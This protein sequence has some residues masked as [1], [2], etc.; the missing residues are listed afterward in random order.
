MRFLWA[1]LGCLTAVFAQNPNPDPM[2]LLATF[3]G[4]QALLPN[5]TGYN[6]TVIRVCVPHTALTGEQKAFVG[7]W[8]NQFHPEKSAEF[9]YTGVLEATQVLFSV[10]PE[11]MCHLGLTYSLSL[12]ALV[13]QGL[14][15]PLDPYATQFQ[16]AKG[17]NPFTDITLPSQYDLHIV[18]PGQ[19]GPQ[20]FGI[21]FIVQNLAL[22]VN[23]TTLE[24]LNLTAPPPIN[25]ASVWPL[26]YGNSWT[27]AEFFHYVEVLYAAGIE[28]PY[29]TEVCEFDQMLVAFGLSLNVPLIKADGTC[30]WQDPVFEAGVATSIVPLLKNKLVMF[31]RWVYMNS[32]LVQEF[33]NTPVGEWPPSRPLPIPLGTCTLSNEVQGFAT[34]Y[35]GIN[36]D[37]GRAAS[38]G[39]VNTMQTWSWGIYSNSSDPDL[40][41]DFLSFLIDCTNPTLVTLMETY[42]IMP[43]FGHC[44]TAAPALDAMIANSPSL[45]NA[46][47]ERIKSFPMTYPGPPPAHT[48]LLETLSFHIVFVGTIMKQLMPGYNWT[49]FRVPSYSEIP[50]RWGKGAVYYP[51]PPN[52]DPLTIAKTA[53]KEACALVNYISLPTCRAKNLQYAITTCDGTNAQATPLWNSAEA[54]V[55]CLATDFANWTLAATPSIP[56]TCPYDTIDTP[57]G[58]ASIIIPGLVV[59]MTLGITGVLIKYWDAF[60]FRV[61]SRWISLLYLLGIV[62]M[63]LAPPLFLVSGIGSIFVLSNGHLLSIGGVWAKLRRLY[64][65]LEAGDKLKSVKIPDSTLCL[66]ILVILLGNN[67]IFAINILT[68]GP[69]Y[70]LIPVTQPGDGR[71]IQSVLQYNMGNGWVYALWIV[72]LGVLLGHSAKMAW[73]LSRYTSSDEFKKST[74]ESEAMLAIMRAAQDSKAMMA[75]IFID[76]VFISTSLI[77]LLAVPTWQTIV[78]TL[79]GVV[80]ILGFL[81][82]VIYFVPRFY[83]LYTDPT[84]SQ[85]GT[86]GPNN[87]DPES[88]KQRKLADIQKAKEK[89][90]FG[91][92]LEI[93]IH[94]GGR[95]TASGGSINPSQGEGRSVLSQ[96]FMENR[97]LSREN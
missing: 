82:N 44:A 64:K 81:M 84:A 50:E 55:T 79:L 63:L 89:A 23:L 42:Q 76:S 6:E 53:I 35:A 46:Q 95:N 43:N 93:Q 70:V 2:T 9:Y 77:I 73:K 34:I 29:Q 97:V 87:E 10:P 74:Q 54:N 92:S 45:Q 20:W 65:V 14:M 88:V 5:Q 60:I 41:W 21:P 39:P 71:Y 61:S 75:I 96:N 90:H 25:N 58:I 94:G 1:L 32:T 33:M 66:Y 36:P 28:E 59:L 40:A 7:A 26:P 56:T 31:A 3:H 17:Y 48:D 62:I 30:G 4:T 12:P 68:M 49:G 16:I 85:A 27:W 52:Y 51:D 19:T 83:Q 38:P 78:T 8:I 80:S 72:Y 69:T 22:S 86:L 18:A 47:S 91:S 57:L 13:D 11:R 15:L 37:M 24:W 67:V